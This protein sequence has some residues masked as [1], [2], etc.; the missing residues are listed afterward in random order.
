MT[1]ELNKVTF[2]NTPKK[3]NALIGTYNYYY[4]IP[5]GMGFIESNVFHSTQ[6]GEFCGENTAIINSS[7]IQDTNESVD[8]TLVLDQGVLNKIKVAS[9]ES[10]QGNI[11]DITGVL[12][13]KNADLATA[14][15]DL[16]SGLYIIGKKKVLIK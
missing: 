13:K 14:A 7:D 9:T 5:E 8:Y 12:I 6:T 2:E 15:K 1:G 10:A 16:K 3:A 4:N 11:Y